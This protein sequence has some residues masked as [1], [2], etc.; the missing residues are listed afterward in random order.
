[1]NLCTKYE[2]C[3]LCDYSGLD[4]AFELKPSALAEDYRKAPGTHTLYPLEL[5]LCKKCRHLQLLHSIDQ[6]YLFSNYSYQSQSSPGLIEHFRK[7]A[8]TLGS[9]LNK[10]AL[11]V[12]IGSN[13]GTLLYEFKKLGFD[14]LVGV[15]P[16]AE[17]CVNSVQPGVD[18]ICSF[19]TMEVTKQIK[20]L[21]G[22]AKLIT[23]NNVFAHS[24]D[25]GLM[26]D[27]VYELLDKDGQFII[28]V[29][30][31]PLMMKNMVFDFIYHEHL[32]YHRF[33]P[34]QK[35]F[36]NRSMRIIKIEQ[37]QMKGGSARF[38]VVKSSSELQ[39]DMSLH[40]A[41]MLEREMSLDSILSYRQFFQQIEIVK[42]DVLKFL[43]RSD[44]DQRVMVGYGASATT[45]TLLHHFELG[46]KIQFLVDDNP[47]KIG[48]HSPGFNIPV[49]SPKEIAFLNPD[50][51]FITAWRFAN[52][53]I[54]KYKD[55]HIPFVVPLPELRVV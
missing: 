25:L 54:E 6:T 47:A 28:E 36:Q 41:T 27:A 34:L 2:T 45:T 11:I 18:A 51:I 35:F 4:L 1:M 53:I 29:S 17:L 3:V 20:E 30:Y 37:S 22:P 43:S 48:T 38:T 32:C 14:K 12:D 21:H 33:E 7:Y 39:A 5:Y 50:L 10:D 44:I 19:F 42:R 46:S 55:Q 8:E 49:H 13:D 26:A 16:S 9:S 40:E 52:R 23:A 31:L 15:E 24:R